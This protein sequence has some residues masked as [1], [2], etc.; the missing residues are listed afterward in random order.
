MNATNKRK[1]IAAVERL[2]RSAFSTVSLEDG[3]GLNEGL[4]IDSYASNF[5][6][7]AA[8]QVDEKQ[9]WSL[10]PSQELN[11]AA[12]SLAYFDAKGM[13]FHLP[14]F[15]IADLHGQLDQDVRFHLTTRGLDDRYSLFTSEQKLAVRRYLELQLALLPEPNAQF[16]Q[17]SIR[18]SIDGFWGVSVE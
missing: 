3:V 12:T 8:R 11:A 7:A 4:E 18:D 2:I 15:L 1:M 6:R 14:A 13:R 16:E 9:D 10:I 17:C 5:D